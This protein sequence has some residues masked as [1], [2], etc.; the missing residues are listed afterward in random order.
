MYG[1]W[2]DFIQSG[3]QRVGVRTTIDNSRANGLRRTEATKL[4]LRKLFR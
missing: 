2:L 1:Q 3:Q 4:N